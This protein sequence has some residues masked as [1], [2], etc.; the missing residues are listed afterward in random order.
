MKVSFI[1]KCEN[2][3]NNKITIEIDTKSSILTIE[4]QR[5]QNEITIMMKVS[6]F[7]RINNLIDEAFKSEGY[8]NA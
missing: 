6:D 2:D 8:K 3:G 4:N 7:K 5:G 1:Y